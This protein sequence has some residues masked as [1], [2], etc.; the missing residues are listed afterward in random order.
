MKN[1]SEYYEGQQQY[2]TGANVSIFIDNI[3]LDEVTM[4]SWRGV[5]GDTPLYSYNEEHF[6]SLAKGVYR[7]EGKFSINYVT[8]G[9][10]EYIIAKAANHP[11]NPH[12][13]AAEDVTG[14]VPVGRFDYQVEKFKRSENRI[15]EG[16]IINDKYVFDKFKAGVQVGT[17]E[18]VRNSLRNY[19]WGNKT[20]KIK[21]LGKNVGSVLSDHYFNILVI[22]GNPNSDSY[23]MH[24]IINAKIID[25]SQ[26][27]AAD[28]TP[29]QEVYTFLAQDMDRPLFTDHAIEHP[30]AGGYAEKPKISPQAMLGYLKVLVEKFADQN[31]LAPILDGSTRSNF[32]KVTHK[33]MFD[34]GDLT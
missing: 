29:I 33:Q 32:L 18:E 9:Y 10:L 27:S 3:Y 26:Q 6:N 13:E 2:Y 25:V 19:L 16:D 5:R 20:E 24:N 7:V 4:I 8:T 1:I 30:L 21:S 34:T 22:Y 31:I 15:R 11:A 12:G 17:I 14:A 23:T 28:G